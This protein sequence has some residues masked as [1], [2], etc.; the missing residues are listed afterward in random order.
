DLGEVVKAIRQ[1]IWLHH[2]I[3]V[4]AIALVPKGAVPKTTSGKVQRRLCRDRLV[5]RELPQPPGWQNAHYE[6]SSQL[7]LDSAI[8]SPLEAR[9]AKIW[10]QAFG[11]ASIGLHQHFIDLGGHSLLAAETVLQIKRALGFDISLRDLYEHPTVTELAG[12]IESNQERL[13]SSLATGSELPSIVPCPSQAHEPF[14]LTDI[15]QAYLVGRSHDFE[16]GGVATHVYLELSRQELDPER[17][18]RALQILIARHGSLRTIFDDATQRVLR[19]VPPYEVAVHDLRQMSAAGQQVAL[20]AMRSKMSHQVFNPA[21][22]P[23][24]QVTLSVLDGSTRIHM[25]WDML[26]VDAWSLSIIDAELSHLYGALTARPSG[27]ESL[28][29]GDALSFRDCQLALEGLS[30]SPRAL[31]DRKYWFDRLDKLP[32]GPQ[33]PLAVAPSSLKKNAFERRSRQLGIQQWSALR[34]GASTRGLTPSCVL[35][36]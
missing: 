19:E 24:F 14:G 2:D 10:A 8:A 18:Q 17:F 33:L 26:V 21:S 5:T 36:S 15:Q 20:A 28:S 3:D 1:A 25:S 6:R 31:R 23:L 34:R 7:S 12:F 11:L 4:Y 13:S 16:L 9:L 22:W 32:R 35:L 29:C 30:D 27:D